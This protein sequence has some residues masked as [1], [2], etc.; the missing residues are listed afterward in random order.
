MASM[1]IIGPVVN[2]YPEVDEGDEAHPPHSELFIGEGIYNINTF[3]VE[4]THME[5]TVGQIWPR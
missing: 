1:G 2:R 3:I 4:G 5:P